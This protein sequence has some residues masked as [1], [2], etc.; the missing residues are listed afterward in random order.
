M[1]ND[2]SWRGS[3]ANTTADGNASTF[4]SGFDTLHLY[5]HYAF[6]DLAVDYA[7]PDMPVQ[8]ATGGHNHRPNTLG[9]G[10]SSTILER[11]HDLGQIASK[12]YSLYLGNAFNRAGGIFNGSNV[13]GGYDSSRFKGPV[14][15]YPMDFSS[16]DYLPVTV[17]DIIIDHPSNPLHE[18]ISI[19][20]DSTFEAKISTDRYPMTLPYSVTTRFINT[21]HAA[22]AQK[23]SD[24]DQGRALHLTRPF[25]GTLTVV[26]AGGFNVTLP[27]EAITQPGD[28]HLSSILSVPQ[29]YTGPYYL[30]SAWLSQVYLML[31]YEAKQ[32]HLAQA[33][34]DAQHSSP[35]PF[36]SG[37]IPMARGK[38]HRHTSLSKAHI[39][40]IIGGVVGGAFFI[41]ALLTACFV[42][43]RRQLARQRRD[44]AERK[45]A[46]AAYGSSGLV[47]EA[48]RAGPESKRSISSADLEKQKSH[49]YHSGAYTGFSPPGSSLA[50]P[51]RAYIPV[52]DTRSRPRTMSPVIIRSR[53]V[54]PVSSISRYSTHSVVSLPR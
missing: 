53:S 18:R 33:I 39:G 10:S 28:Q 45:A 6:A 12:T 3:F 38:T 27:P 5:T 44:W 30:S 49:Q 17:T 34:P 15:T 7:I 2:S 35:K 22:P 11:M 42:Y 47:H 26:L 40:A 50:S 43:K 20:A 37:S 14:Y 25:N 29:N 32:F 19:M 46:T 23:T 51:T 54:S 31:D 41:L 1:T 9:L 52:S 13:F 4:M 16:P 36:C 24:S 21:V 48:G 8:I